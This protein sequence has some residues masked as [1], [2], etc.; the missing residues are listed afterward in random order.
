MKDKNWDALHA[1]MDT[2]LDTSWCC[3][4]KGNPTDSIVKNTG[5]TGDIDPQCS[6]EP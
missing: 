1:N 6:I 5:E 4:L 3:K 2:G